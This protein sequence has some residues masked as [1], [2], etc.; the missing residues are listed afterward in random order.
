M[1][2]APDENAM[3]VD[4]EPDADIAP[5]QLFSSLASPSTHAAPHTQP[6]LPTGQPAS[7]HNDYSQSL[8]PPGFGDSTLGSIPGVSGGVGTGENGRRPKQKQVFKARPKPLQ[9][10][11]QHDRRRHS[12]ASGGQVQTTLP[13]GRASPNTPSTTASTA[14]QSSPSSASSLPGQRDNSPLGDQ[15]SSPSAMPAGQASLPVQ[16][17]GASSLRKSS[18][19]EPPRNPLPSIGVQEP[20]LDMFSFGDAPQNK[21]GEALF[22][23][24]G[25]PPVKG[26]HPCEFVHTAVQE[27]VQTASQYDQNFSLLP[28][29][30][31]K[32]RAPPIVASNPSS[33]PNDYTRLCAYV[34]VPNDSQ[35]KWARGVDRATGKK[36]EQAKVYATL[37]MNSKIDPRFLVEALTPIMDMKHLFFEV[38][39]LQRIRT[40]SPWALGGTSP[41]VCPV[42]LAEVLRMALEEELSRARAGSKLAD[43]DE[44]PEFVIQMKALRVPS[45]DSADKLGLTNLE[46]Y[47]TMLRRAPHIEVSQYEEEELSL[48]LLAAEYS[49][50]LKL[51][52][53]SKCRL[54]DLSLKR[55]T[56]RPDKLN[57]HKKVD[58]HMGYLANTATVEAPSITD[59]FHKVPVAMEPLED[60][61]VPVRPVKFTSVYRELTSYES[62]DG[63]QL[64]DSMIPVRSGPS[65][66]KTTVVFLQSGDAEQLA[67]AFA[68]DPAPWIFHTSRKKGYRLDMCYSLLKSFDHIARSVA[69]ETEWD[70]ENWVVVNPNHALSDTWAEDLERE[71]YLLAVTVIWHKPRLS[72]SI[73]PP[74]IKF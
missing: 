60:G 17:T 36:R 44:V 27:I 2:A 5:R 38:K 23:T 25:I 42:G 40:V 73:S 30:T 15:V 24:V 69:L 72:R 43:I 37:L 34:D 63:L 46:A 26:R 56:T 9:E 58:G 29:W 68:T 51:Y 12:K 65:E 67:T 14:S 53:S 13:F 54:I 4:D 20:L 71:G 61:S 64:I 59:L 18:Y 8:S 52:I 19:A 39:H 74:R 22:I 6:S 1:N 31:D 11:L 35:M 21:S 33:F 49:G 41:D 55:N 48:L 32:T 62:A 66:G 70:D 45:I 10:R 3:D 47:S 28:L 7:T 57:K 50:I 16:T